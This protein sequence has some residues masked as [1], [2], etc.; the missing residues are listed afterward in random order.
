ME[1]SIEAAWVRIKSLEG[2]EFETKSGKP[3]T[4]EIS[5]NVFR[6]SRAEQNITKGDFEKAL[7]LS[8]L[9]GPSE[10]R[11]LVRGSAYIWAVLHDPRIRKGE[12]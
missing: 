4:Y 1:P 8:P 5:G 12:W 10:I 3:F 7:E 9:D 2:E 6:S 11:D